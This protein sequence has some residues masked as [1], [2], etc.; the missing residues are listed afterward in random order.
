MIDCIVLTLN[1]IPSQT[2]TVV[3]IQYMTEMT[4]VS[5]L[6]LFRTNGRHGSFESGYLFLD[7]RLT[8]SKCTVS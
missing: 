7:I 8:E 4:K 2:L 1:I 3:C 5:R 6:L